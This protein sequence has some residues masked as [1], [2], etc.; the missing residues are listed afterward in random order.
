MKGELLY[1]LLKKEDAEKKEL[2]LIDY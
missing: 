2:G 1:A